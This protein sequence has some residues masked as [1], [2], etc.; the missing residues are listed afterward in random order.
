MVADTKKVNR[1]E[2]EHDEEQTQNGGK[3]SQ[4]AVC[5]SFTRRMLTYFGAPL[6]AARILKKAYIQRLEGQIIREVYSLPRDIKGAM[7]TNVVNNQ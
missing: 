3:P 2:Y 1:K 7:I 4:E 6:V 5:S